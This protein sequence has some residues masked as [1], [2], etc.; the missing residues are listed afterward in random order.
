VNILDV[1]RKLKFDMYIEI[2]PRE[3][4]F[5]CLVDLAAQSD[6]SAMVMVCLESWDRHNNGWENYVVRNHVLFAGMTPDFEMT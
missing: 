5:H 6:W 2:R 1:L 3:K 4:V